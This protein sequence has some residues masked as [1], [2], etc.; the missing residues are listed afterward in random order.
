MTGRGSCASGE[1]VRLS[2][3]WKFMTIVC[4]HAAVVLL[5]DCRLLLTSHVCISLAGRHALISLRALQLLQGNPL[6]MTLQRRCSPK[7]SP[8]C[9]L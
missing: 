6:L 2:Q 1:L 5:R 4:S 8:I 7:C 9:L 3:L